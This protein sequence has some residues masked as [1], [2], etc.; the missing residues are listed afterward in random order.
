MI[1]LKAMGKTLLSILEI[2][3]II[4]LCLGGIIGAL[5]IQRYPNIV[6]TIGI[7]IGI[8]II[9]ILLIILVVIIIFAIIYATK[10]NYEEYMRQSKNPTTK[11]SIQ[12]N[13]VYEE[14]RVV[15]GKTK[16][17][18][19]NLLYGELAKKETDSS[20]VYKIKKIRKW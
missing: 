1:L 14:C 11:Y 4:S 20:Y 18:A 3:L 16:Q 2:V 8:V 15:A 10:E 6:A 12:Y 9:S 13:K 19:I 7:G 5:Y 17:E